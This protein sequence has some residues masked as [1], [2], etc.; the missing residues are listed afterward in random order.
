[1]DITIRMEVAFSFKRDLPDDLN[2]ISIAEG[3]SVLDALGAL[4]KAAPAVTGRIFDAN[5][6]VR[7]HINVLV[8]GGNVILRKGLETLLR[9]G[10]CLTILPPVGGG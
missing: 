6:E 8:N 1:M 3:S 5:G 4:S 10:D 7:R 2:P 9:D